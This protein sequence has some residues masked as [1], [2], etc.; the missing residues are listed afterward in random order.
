MVALPEN[1][2]PMGDSIATFTG[3]LTS[4]HWSRLLLWP[5]DTLRELWQE[6]DAAV[7]KNAAMSFIVVCRKYLVILS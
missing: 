1:D 7:R 5:V 3:T 2:M 4:C 6:I